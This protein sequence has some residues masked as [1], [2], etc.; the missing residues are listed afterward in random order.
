MGPRS[1]LEYARANQEPVG[2]S[3]GHSGAVGTTS[4]HCEYELVFC[5]TPLYL[6]NISVPLNRLE[7]VLYLE[8]N[9]DFS[10]QKRNTVKKIVF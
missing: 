7:M 2:A 10:F 3:K 5:E 4:G 9:R 8:L 6:A 1:I